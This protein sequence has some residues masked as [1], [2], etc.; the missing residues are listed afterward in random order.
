MKK[1][2]TYENDNDLYRLI[3]TPLTDEIVLDF[4]FKKCGK[5][6]YNNLA[7]LINTYGKQ[8]VTANL[9]SLKNKGLIKYKKYPFCKVTLKARW[10][11]II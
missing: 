10:K 11:R 9:V 4:L 7:Y 8:D 6:N 2:I 3:N 1:V 5:V